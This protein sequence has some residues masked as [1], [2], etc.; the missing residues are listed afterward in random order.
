M[1]IKTKGPEARY[2]KALFE[3]A[4]EDGI[5]KMLEAVSA[6]EVAVQ[7]SSELVSVLD[8][9]K[10]S[11]SEKKKV[12]EKILSTMYAPK[13]LVRFVDFLAD[14]KRLSL[15]PGVLAEFARLYEVHA[16]I[17]RADV[18]T[19]APMTD[20]QRESVFSFVEKKVP[21]AKEIILDEHIDTTLISGV[22]VR[23]G[24]VNYDASVRGGLN[25][26]RTALIS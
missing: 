20:D 16:S 14:K 24:T 5:E 3:L 12:L 13:L 25:R 4:L 21:E 15:L 17:T 22:Q 10:I 1:Q 26:L 7:E 18:F 23:I 6:F 2:A 19:A 11:L 8:S 9:P